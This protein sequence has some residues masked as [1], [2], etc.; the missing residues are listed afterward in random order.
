[1]KPVTPWERYISARGI[2]ISKPPPPES[3]TFCLYSSII[4]SRPPFLTRHSSFWTIDWSSARATKGRF[5][6]S[7]V[8]SGAPFCS[9]RFTSAH[10]GH[11]YRPGIYANPLGSPL[12]PLATPTPCRPCLSLS[13]PHQTI[14]LDLYSCPKSTDAPA[15]HLKSPA[16]RTSSPTR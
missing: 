13:V 1:V 9:H 15:H 6:P 3:S 12:S 2:E 10:P 5:S 14:N 8:R 16:S 11:I 7:C 4:P